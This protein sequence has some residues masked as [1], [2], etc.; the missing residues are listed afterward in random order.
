[1]LM[2]T[3]YCPL[4]GAWMPPP[5]MAI[6]MSKVRGRCVLGSP[7]SGSCFLGKGPRRVSSM[8]LSQTY[9]LDDTSSVGSKSHCSPKLQHQHV[10][11]AWQPQGSRTQAAGA[12]RGGKLI[13]ASIL[14][15]RHPLFFKGLHFQHSSSHLNFSKA[16]FAYD[17]SPV[18]VCVC[19]GGCFVTDRF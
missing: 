6:P 4:G 12:E 7:F 16:H 10:T 1:M 19:V 5:I 11:S 2:R 8:S 3:C 18:H 15:H 17:W 13:Q 9:S 14:F